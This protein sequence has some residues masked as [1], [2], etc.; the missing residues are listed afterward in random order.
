MSESDRKQDREGGERNVRELLW[1][2]GWRGKF[3]LCSVFCVTALNYTHSWT[4][5]LNY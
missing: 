5:H 3:L 1:W 4:K 2:W